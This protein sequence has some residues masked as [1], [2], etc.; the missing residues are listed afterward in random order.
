MK[1]LTGQEIL[2]VNDADLSCKK[3]DIQEMNLG[4]LNFTGSDLMRFNLIVYS[5]KLGTK[6]LKSEHF[7][8]GIIQ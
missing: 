2:I 8:G 1:K 5:G 4:S 7:G 3:P 6:I